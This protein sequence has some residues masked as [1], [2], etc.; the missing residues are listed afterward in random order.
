MPTL[1]KSFDNACR[2]AAELLDR[3]RQRST[4]VVESRCPVAGIRYEALTS[5]EIAALPRVPVIVARVRKHNK[6]HLTPQK[7]A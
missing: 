3:Y 2:E 6:R 1:H 5:A 4:V 7:A